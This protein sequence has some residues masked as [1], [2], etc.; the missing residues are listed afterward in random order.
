MPVMELPSF[1]G[2]VAYRVGD[3]VVTLD[4]IENGILRRNAPHPVSKAPLFDDDGQ[5]YLA[6]FGTYVDSG[7]AVVP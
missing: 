1:F 6:E 7:G 3:H 2:V 4:E 5:S